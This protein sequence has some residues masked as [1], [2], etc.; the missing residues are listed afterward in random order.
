MVRSFWPDDL[1]LVIVVV[2]DEC[3]TAPCKSA[4]FQIGVIHAAHPNVADPVLENVYTNDLQPREIGWN[5]F[6]V[7]YA[8]VHSHGRD[9]WTILCKEMLGTLDPKWQVRFSE[10]LHVGASSRHLTL[11]Y[12]EWSAA[13]DVDAES[14]HGDDKQTENDKRKTWKHET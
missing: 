9:V 2:R 12:R 4:C 5:R 13:I 6:A 3:E 11:P 14:Y 1:A 8:V 10:R 7:G